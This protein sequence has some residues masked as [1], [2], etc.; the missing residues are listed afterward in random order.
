MLRCSTTFLLGGTTEVPY[1]CR[2]HTGP[3]VVGGVDDVLLLHLS[4]KGRNT[5]YVDLDRR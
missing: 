2:T 1:C 3:S 4:D 5:G